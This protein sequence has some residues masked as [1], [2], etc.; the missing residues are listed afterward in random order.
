MRKGMTNLVSKIISTLEASD[1]LNTQEA[2]LQT[3][4]IF[5]K[6]RGVG[7]N[8]TPEKQIESLGWTSEVANESFSE[9][10]VTTLKAALVR[11][12]EQ[13]PEDE[14]ASSALWALGKLMD[15]STKDIFISALMKYLNGDAGSLYQ[16]MIGLDNIG[17]GAFFGKTKTSILNTEEKNRHLAKMYLEEK[18]PI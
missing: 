15:V 8:L 13:I 18:G 14:S 1:P 7:A 6:F 10:D 9:M 3:A 17:E 11:Y 5:E 4:F 2:L 12:I 16:A